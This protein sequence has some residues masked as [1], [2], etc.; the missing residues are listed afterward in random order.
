M[1]ML[2][3]KLLFSFLFITTTNLNIHATILTHS[4]L[5]E[6]AS[7]YLHKNLLDLTEKQIE[8]FIADV[9]WEATKNSL[10]K[11]GV[12]LDLIKKIESSIAYNKE[13]MDKKWDTENVS[14]GATYLGM[15]VIVACLQYNAYYKWHKPLKDEIADFHR[16]Y[17]I[18][19]RT[20]FQ[21]NNTTKYVWGAGKETDRLVKI[22]K[23]DHTF[24]E[25]GF[26]SAFMCAFSGGSGLWL[27][28]CGLFIHPKHQAQHTAYYEKLCIIKQYLDKELNQYNLSNSKFDF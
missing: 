2:L 26:F 11:E 16:R 13:N 27:L 8:S 18:T 5:V 14:W 4:E 23:D 15:A 1:K 20:E 17:T 12:L 7:S 10:Y 3:R 25:M 28:F 19:T 21:G 22:M 24:D 9:L 6:Q